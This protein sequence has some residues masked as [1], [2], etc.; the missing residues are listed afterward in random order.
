MRNLKP[1]GIILILLAFILTYAV[2]PLASL[3]NMS[4]AL[5]WIFSPFIVL[6]GVILIINQNI[7]T[8]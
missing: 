3:S 7:E 4:N 1:I 5:I 2:V 6:I 8:K